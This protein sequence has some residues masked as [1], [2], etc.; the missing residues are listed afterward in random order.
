MANQ[1]LA[2]SLFIMLLA[3]FIVLNVMSSFEE[4]KSRPVLRSISVAFS[5]QELPEDLY[6][7]VE[8]SPED[9]L[10]EGD[11]L[12]KIQALFKGTISGIET[13]QNRLGTM[14]H[15][16][17]PV[18]KFEQS[19]AESPESPGPSSRLKM[20]RGPLV[21][22]LVTLMNTKE[23]IPYRMDMVL[24]LP[25]RPGAMK[26]EELPALEA[27]LEKVSGYAEKLEAAGLPEKFITAGLAA[28]R[29][30]MID[31]YFNRYMPFDPTS[32]KQDNPQ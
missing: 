8:E 7:G 4:D 1:F 22:T 31:L 12:D 32:Q 10:G 20:I 11:T 18:E 27:G 23:G 15:I 13:K 28:G 21:Q 16:R 29:E 19:F 25:E 5:N 26:E 6:Q 17:M 2:L 24:N 30:G 9:L 14:M 3:F